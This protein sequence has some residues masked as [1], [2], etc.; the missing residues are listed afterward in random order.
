M[1]LSIEVINSDAMPA[2]TLRE[3]CDL[4]TEAYG[5]DF[6]Q[7]LE[8]LGSGVHVVGRLDGAIVS[9]A[10]WVTRALE[11]DGRASLRTAYVEAVATKPA[12]QR[13]GFASSILRRL[14]AEIGDF[15]LGALSPSE[16]SFYARLGWESWRGRL[17]IRTDDG[18][19]ATP[20]ESVM[21]L[22]LPR[23]PIDLDLNASLSAEWRPGEL[24]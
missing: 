5:E 16:P 3:I 10:M 19:Q 24:W 9:H 22:R 7:Y 20:D 15:D 11:L 21:I 1:P 13:R 4:C 23:T 12:Y 17:L 2:S 6:C 8:F 14:A 18:L